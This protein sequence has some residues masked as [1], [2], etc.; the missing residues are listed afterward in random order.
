MMTTIVKLTVMAS[1]V[2]LMGLLADIRSQPS[3]LSLGLQWVS[4]AHAVLGTRRRTRRRSVAVGA[5]VGAAAASSSS[6]ASESQ[7]QPAAQPQPAA[8]PPPTYG[9][10]PLGSVVPAL[11]AGCAS[12]SAGGVEYYHCGDN[13]FRA[14]FQGNT[15]VYVTASPE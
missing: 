11:P 9:P 2:V 12:M 15:L 3:G 7:Q 4:E 1:V 5:A 13:Y 10:L 6:A 14:A 8:A